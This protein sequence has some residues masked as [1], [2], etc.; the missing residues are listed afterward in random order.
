VKQLLLMLLFFSFNLSAYDNS[1]AIL[2]KKLNLYAG[3]KA[4]I[5]WERVFSSQRHLK[6]YKLDTLSINERKELKKFL[7]QHA[8]DSDQPIVPGL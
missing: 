6:K 4:T 2:S 7:I 5:Q 1:M 8:A 3:S